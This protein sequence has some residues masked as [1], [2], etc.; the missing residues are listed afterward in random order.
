MDL[1][2]LN[3]RLAIKVSFLGSLPIISEAARIRPDADSQD[4]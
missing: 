2:L 4:L 1:Q 3:M